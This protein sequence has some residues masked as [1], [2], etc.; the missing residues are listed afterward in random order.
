MRRDNLDPWTERDI[1]L[2][3]VSVDF[4]PPANPAVDLEP[5]GSNDTFYSRMFTDDLTLGLLPISGTTRA[6]YF[7]IALDPADETRERM[8]AD[9]LSFG[10]TRSYPQDLEAALAEWSRFCATSLL[11]H[12][13]AVYEL[14]YWIRPK[15]RERVGFA[16]IPLRGV[17][18]RRGTHEQWVPSGARVSGTAQFE[19][20]PSPERRIRL[21]AGRVLLISLPPELREI[22]RIV[23]ALKTLGHGRLPNFMIPRFDTPSTTRVP[24]DF[25]LM[26]RTEEVAV[27]QVTRATG[28][29]ARSISENRTE[30]YAAARALRGERVK[31]M[32]R[33]VLLDA[34]DEV[35]HRAGTT[36]QFT[37]RL[38][39]G[40]LPTINDVLA[41]EARLAAG[42]VSPT[43]L[44]RPFRLW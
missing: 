12:G 30:Y 2:D 21:P 19:H 22:A 29:N 27:A 4:Y 42:D 34:I 17:I 23:P 18:Y 40:G 3:R 41:A 14:A 25:D 15:T 6:Q 38:K 33:K 35:L 10:D 43:D 13:Q 44:L 7:T 1:E 37:A 31:C 20:S 26:K 24:F 28:W 16:L 36:L 5:D 11:S 9:A 32:L 8:L 39:V